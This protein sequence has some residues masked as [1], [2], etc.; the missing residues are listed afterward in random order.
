MLMF[1]DRCVRI[2]NLFDFFIE[3]F[4]GIYGRGKNFLEDLIKV[5]V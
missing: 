3:K 4:L 5:K 2:F 1:M